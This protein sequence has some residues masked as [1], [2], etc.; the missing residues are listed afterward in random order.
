MRLVLARLM[1]AFDIQLADP[2]DVWD[3]AKQKTF[4]FWEKEP[5]KVFLRSAVR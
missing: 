5:L 1:Y 4:F 2:K 3:W